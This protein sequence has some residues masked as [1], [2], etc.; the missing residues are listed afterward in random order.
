MSYILEELFQ[1]MANLYSKMYIVD[2]YN[3]SQNTMKLQ[4]GP[5]AKYSDHAISRCEMWHM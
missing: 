5:K 4:K 2:F 1:L 3:E